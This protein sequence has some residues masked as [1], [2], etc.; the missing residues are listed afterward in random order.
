VSQLANAAISASKSIDY[1]L[2]KLELGEQIGRG[3]TGNSLTLFSNPSDHS[4][5]WSKC[6]AA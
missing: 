6:Q 2:A 5:V 1:Y 3:S 4:S